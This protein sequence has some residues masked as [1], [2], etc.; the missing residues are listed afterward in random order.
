VKGSSLLDIYQQWRE[1]VVSYLP[2]WTALRE[3]DRVC[4]VLDPDP[5]TPAHLYR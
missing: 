2:V 1:A 3:L 5:P 4:W